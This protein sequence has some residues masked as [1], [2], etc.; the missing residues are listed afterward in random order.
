MF[1]YYF[2]RSDDDQ[3]GPVALTLLWRVVSSTSEDHAFADRRALWDR[4]MNA[5]Q[6]PKTLRRWA[7]II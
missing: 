3:W 6:L 7:Y 5:E 1:H 4:R 2:T